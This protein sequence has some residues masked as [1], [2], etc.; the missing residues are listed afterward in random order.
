M[1]QVVQFLLRNTPVEPDRHFNFNILSAK[2]IKDIIVTNYHYLIL[3]VILFT[4]P[5]ILF[6][7]PIIRFQPTPAAAWLRLVIPQLKC[8]KIVIH[9]LNDFCF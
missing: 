7:G 4:A 6:K 9:S 5:I 3:V 1:D 2:R 8:L